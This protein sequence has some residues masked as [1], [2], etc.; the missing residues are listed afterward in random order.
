MELIGVYLANQEGQ[1]LSERKAQ[2]NKEKGLP[3]R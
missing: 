3:P 2:R 1:A